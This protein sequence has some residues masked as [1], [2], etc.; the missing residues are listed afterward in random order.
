MSVSMVEEEKRP[1][2]GQTRVTKDLDEIEFPTSLD[3][4]AILT[5]LLKISFL[6]L[7]DG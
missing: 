4:L 2:S 5:C 1:C 3:I 6:V 7:V